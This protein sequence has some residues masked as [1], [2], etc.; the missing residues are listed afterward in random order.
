MAFFRPEALRALTR[1]RE[2]LSGAGVVLLGG[3]VATWGGPFFA[4]LGGGVALVGIGLAVIGL[5]RLRF[6]QGVRDPGVVEVIEGQI[7]YFGPLQGGY[8]ALSDLTEIA[9]VQHGGQRAWR[10]GQ[11]DA[12]PLHVPVAAA[13]AEALFDTFAGLPGLEMQSLLDA[14]EAPPVSARIVWRRRAQKL[15]HAHS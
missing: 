6:S 7:G 8:A 2:P 3:W 1:L 9:L 12:P 10:L 14:L 15:L 11:S 5:R 13:G 4:A